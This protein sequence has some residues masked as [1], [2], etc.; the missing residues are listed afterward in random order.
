MTLIAK[1][2]LISNFGEGR[3]S[4]QFAANEINSEPADVVS[5][6]TVVMNSEDTREMNGVDT[7]CLGDG[8]DGER[9]GKM[10]VD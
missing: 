8:R 5:N 6:C 4:C 7:Y 9:V 3:R 10:R 1:A 2:C